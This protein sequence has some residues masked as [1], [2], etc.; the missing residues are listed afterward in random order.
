VIAQAA[1]SLLIG[2]NLE[3]AAAQNT[4]LTHRFLEDWGYQTVTRRTARTEA[5][6]LWGR[7]EPNP[8]RLD[9]QS[10]LCAYIEQR[11]AECLA[12]LQL[13]GVGQGLHLESGS[14]RLPW[15]RTFEVDFRTV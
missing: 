14:V 3:R 5:E 15:R 2:D 7:R 10:I 8:D 6:R 13:R 1:C 4:F 9:E 11:L 12:T